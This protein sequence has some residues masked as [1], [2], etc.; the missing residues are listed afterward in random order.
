MKQRLLATGLS[1]FI[2]I[3]YMISTPKW[4]LCVMSLLFVVWKLLVKYPTLGDSW[5]ITLYSSITYC[6]CTI[7]LLT[8]MYALLSPVSPPLSSVSH[9]IIC[10][11]P[12]I[13]HVLRHH[14]PCLPQHRPCPPLSPMC[15]PIIISV[16]P[17]IAH[18]LLQGSN[19][20][21]TISTSCAINV[22]Q[23]TKVKLQYDTHSC[24]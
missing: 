24:M 3:L 19:I 16:S 10:V 23:N 6:L 13:A 17:I 7:P 2:V 5:I 20:S 14:H 11:C 22:E 8:Y 21:P 9:N 12:V 4:Q 15:S 18:V 1:S